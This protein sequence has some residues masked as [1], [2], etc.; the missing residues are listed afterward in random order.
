MSNNM[1]VIAVMLTACACNF[2]TRVF[3]FLL[4][5][6][7]DKL[8]GFIQY[9]GK[10]LPPCVMAVLVVY[11]IKGINFASLAGF[12]PMLI[13][14]VAVVLLHLWKRNNIISIAGGTVLYMILVQV[15]FA[16]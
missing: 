2:F 11:C 14:V 1:Y 8:P 9:L 5:S 10:Y 7:S 16:R 13:S 4:F 12:M 15:V 3:P 6:K